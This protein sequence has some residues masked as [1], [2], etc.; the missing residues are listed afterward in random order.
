MNIIDRLLSVIAPHYCIGC[1]REGLV[2]CME[3]AESI[4][5][6]PSICYSCGKAS[7]AFSMCSDCFGKN[8][9]NNIWVVTNYSDLAKEIVKAFK[10]ESKRQA[11]LEIAKMIDNILPYFDEPPLVTFVPTASSHIRQR[12]LD[13]SKLIAHN[14]ARQREWKCL[15]LLL[16]TSNIRQLGSTRYSRKK[17]L[18][19]VFRV[20]SIFADSCK[21]SNILLIDDVITTGATI[22]ECTKQLYKAGA[23]QVD[24]AVFARTP[25]K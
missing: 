23:K 19:G 10:F 20:N 12:G 9:P 11:A 1:N 13:H 24:V 2:L 6:L 21:N 7:I 3:C 8:K 14:L 4:G 16:R 15:R 5:Q 22:V 25:N 18:S 17:Q